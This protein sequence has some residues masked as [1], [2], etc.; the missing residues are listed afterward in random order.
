MEKRALILPAMFDS[1][2]Q[3]AEMLGVS[4][5]VV[6]SWKKAGC[7]A[8]RNS[9]VDR[10]PLLE[11]FAQGGRDSSEAQA[12][13]NKEQ[14]EALLIR[15]RRLQKEM[16]NAETRKELIPRTEIERVESAFIQS[17]I[18]R[19]DQMGNKLGAVLCPSDPVPAAKTIDDYW[20]ELKR[21]AQSD[22]KTRVTSETDAGADDPD[23]DSSAS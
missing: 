21:L 9:R 3:C 10:D 23:G 19:G 2:A 18:Q 17:I 13:L 20:E 16:Q 12:V 6:Q 14:E 11:W 22:F 4:K 15:E 1:L 8:F 7:P 5:A